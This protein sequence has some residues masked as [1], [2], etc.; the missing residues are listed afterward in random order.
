MS[1]WRTGPWRVHTATRWWCWPPRTRPTPTG[2]PWTHQHP[3]E[4]AAARPG[5]K[6]GAVVV[7]HNGD[8][9]LYM[10]RGG[11][12]ML[13]FT[14]EETLMDR[15]ATALAARLEEAAGAGRL[16]VERINGTAVLQHTFGQALRNAGFD[17]SP[18]GLRFSG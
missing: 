14:D 11:R 1:V 16:A 13:L 6:A 5:R 3:P 7:L 17:S 10:E 2:Q 4:H 15:T 8:L 12:T 9:V 18:S